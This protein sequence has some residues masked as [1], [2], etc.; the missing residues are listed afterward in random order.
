[1]DAGGGT[2]NNKGGTIAHV[3]NLTTFGKKLGN[4]LGNLFAVSRKGNNVKCPEA[5]QVS[6]HL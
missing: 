4:L 1:M 5:I 2:I 3:Q 6:V